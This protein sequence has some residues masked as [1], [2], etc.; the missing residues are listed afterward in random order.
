MHLCRT[1]TASHQ[2]SI[3]VHDGDGHHDGDHEGDHDGDQAP[4]D[5][6]PDAPGPGLSDT[7]AH[8]SRAWPRLMLAE[9]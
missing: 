5:H 1:L 3:L 7:A 2:I 4:P 6:V 8:G 9:G